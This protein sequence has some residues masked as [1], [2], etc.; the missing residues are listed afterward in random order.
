MPDLHRW[1]P[2]AKVWQSNLHWMHMLASLEMLTVIDCPEIRSKAL[3]VRLTVA[4]KMSFTPGAINAYIII[5]V[6]VHH[7]HILDIQPVLYV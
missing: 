1:N 3:M 4:V 5:T 2:V 6:V 7:S